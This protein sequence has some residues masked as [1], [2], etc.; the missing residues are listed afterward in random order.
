MSTERESQIR[1]WKFP[2]RA[3]LLELR[4]PAD[5]EFLHLGMQFNEPFV[6]VKL[7]ISKPLISR[8]LR[9]YG[10]GQTLPEG[11][12]KYIGTFMTLGGADVRHVFE[13]R[14]DCA[15]VGCNIIG[16]HD[17]NVFE[18]PVQGSSIYQNYRQPITI[19][20][21]QV[22]FHGERLDGPCIGCGRE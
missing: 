1:I 10:T 3:D 5:A 13:A 22:C 6:W 9:V 15:V 21:Y 14:T 12:Q 19:G 11:P 8:R 18:G 4:L 20:R 7:D 16:A 2:L 17:H